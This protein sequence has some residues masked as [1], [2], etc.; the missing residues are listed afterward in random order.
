[1]TTA[2]YQQL[3]FDALPPLADAGL[4]AAWPALLTSCRVFERAPA[5]A[6]LWRAPCAAAAAA[7]AG[8]AAALRAVLAAHFDAYR[9][10]AE[11]RE[12]NQGGTGPLL[13]A[14]VTGRITG[15]YE[16]LLA[17]SRSPNGAFT[18]PLHRVP[19]DL[20]TIDLG[21][22][23]PDLRGRRLRGRLLDTPQGRRVVPYWSR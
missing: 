15:Y 11:T 17:G 22:V 14:T 16:P 7:N 13:D 19:D 18:V 5:R 6:P 10:S 23:Y 2:S 21:D 12:E 1:M 4:I 9:I 3:A 8:D 20:L